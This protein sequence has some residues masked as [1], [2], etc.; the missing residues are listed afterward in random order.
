MAGNPPARAAIDAARIF[1]HL[2]GR[3]SVT[4]D[5]PGMGSFRGLASFTPR[6]GD[7]LYDEKGETRLPDGGLI[8]GFRRFLYRLGPSGI[9]I[10]FYDEGRRQTP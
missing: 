2:P 6:D 7:L 1:A 5:I 8:A 3:W 9:E 10:H 4:R